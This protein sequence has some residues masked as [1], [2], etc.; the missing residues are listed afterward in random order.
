MRVKERKDYGKEFR[1]IPIISKTDGTRLLLGDIAN[2]KDDFEET[3]R[4]ALFNGKPAV[5]LDIFRVGDQTPISVSNSVKKR[6]KL[7]KEEVSPHIGI[8]IFDDRADIYRQRLELMIKN[9]SMGAFLVLFLLGMF[10]E[11]KLAFWV[12]LGIPISF[13]GAFIFMPELGLSLN[14]VSMFAMI[15]ALGIL[16]DDAIVVG[17]NI[18]NLHENGM[19]LIDAAIQGTR[20]V[21]VPISFSILTNIAAM[22]PLAFLPGI[23]GKILWMLPA[24]VCLAFI[25][26]WIE[27]IFILPSH[28]GHQSEK[29]KK[30]I[31]LYF[32]SIQQKFSRFF[33][34]AVK[35]IYGPFLAAALKQR[36]SILLISIAIFALFFAFVRSGRM[37][38]ELF[39]KIE[40]DF[41]YAYAKLPYG[42]NFS[43][44]KKVEEILRSS[45]EKLIKQSKHPELFLGIFSDIGKNGSH[46]L[47]MRLYLAAPAI[48]KKILGEN[49]S[50]QKI[51]NDWRKITGEIPGVETLLF[52]ADR[53][54]PGGGSSLT[55]ELKHKNMDILRSAGEDLA[56]ELSKFPI[57]KDI[58]DGFQPG[59]KQYD[60]KITEKGEVMGVT[61][62]YIAKILRD[63]YEG[64]EAIRQQ[65]GRNEI[66]IKIKLLEDERISENDL[67][68][69]II[70]TPSGA[71]TPLRELTQ[72]IEGR[73]YTEITRRNGKRTIQVTADVI[74]RYKT[75]EVINTMEND[76]LPELKKKY[77]GLEYSFEGMQAD[78]RDMFGKLTVFIPILLLFIYIM[79][80]VPFKSYIQ[81]LIIMVSI[82]MGFVGAVIGHFIMGYN[83]SM[84]S[85]IGILALSGVVVNDAI[86]LLDFANRKRS[87]GLPPIRSDTFFWNS[88]FSPY[89]SDYTY[90]FW[91]PCSDDI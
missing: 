36:Y 78:S 26:S 5:I 1:K 28:I 39:P 56:Y 72:I 68:K 62:S 40:S 19:P 18:Y 17:E 60:F 85:I 74:P 70:K 61:P 25:V 82:P 32:H 29:P 42:S 53:G 3:D 31:N 35:N 79:L 43:K 12:M 16:V 13:L 51:V 46:T 24:V 90:Y 76:I 52:Q 50:T 49:G 4:L 27:S 88:A 47:E 33:M 71:E 30:G 20:E 81:P 48:R 45:A 21:A 22:L 67:K 23:M 89:T 57:V 38:F 65:R 63:S 7:L 75:T 14:M 6:I 55:V 41:A 87:E 83:L 58:D 73:A 66:K 11:L 86:V 15:M 84:M 37:G 2:I 34:N 64:A 54:G 77:P 91:W 8:E 44:T 69:L 9:G 10:L 80:A 59:K